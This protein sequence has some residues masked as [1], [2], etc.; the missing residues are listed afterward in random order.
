MEGWT[1]ARLQASRRMSQLKDPLSQNGTN[2]YSA[3]ENAVTNEVLPFVGRR[4]AIVVLTD[5]RDNGYEMTFVTGGLSSN[6]GTARQQTIQ[7]EAQRFNRLLAVIR[8]ERVPIYIV[9]VNTFDAAILDAPAALQKTWGEY[10]ESV[11][12]RLEQ[13]TRSSGGKVVFAS[14]FQD[15]I[16]VYQQLSRQLGSAYTLGYYSNLDTPGHRNVTVTTRNESLSVTQS[17]SGYDV[18]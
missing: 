6:S 18:P 3:L 16:P 14:T 5:G 4:R 8:E 17:R 2:F 15:V 11:N 10:R 13:I 9:A 1:S 7:H 12:K